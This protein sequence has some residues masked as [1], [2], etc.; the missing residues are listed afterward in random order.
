MSAYKY[1]TGFVL[2]GGG[3]RGFAHLG[4]IKA[5]YEKNIYPDVISGVSIGAIVGVLLADGKSPDQILSNF[6]NKSILKFLEIAVPKYGL[7]R[8]TGMA[9]VLREQLVAKNFEELS[10]PLYIAST[11]LNMGKIR[12]FSKGNLNEVVLASSTI[13]GLIKPLKIDGHTYVDGGVLDNFPIKPIW[14]QCDKIIG[15]HINPVNDIDNFQSVVSII[16]HSFTLAISKNLAYKSKRCDLFIEPPLLSNYHITD[17]RK[18]KE[19]FDIGYEFTKE[20]LKSFNI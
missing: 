17:V 9:R 13:P 3:A 6:T 4:A 5:L 2:S 12:Y 15:I 7:T 18:G 10:I 8:F 14:K 16:E 20:K 19:M 1:K 11:N